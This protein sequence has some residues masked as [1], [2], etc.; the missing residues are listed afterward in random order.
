MKV[1][2]MQP[3][4]FPYIGYWQLIHA[5][6]R[7]V[8]YDDVNYIKGGWI[9]R[10]RILVNG[11]PA[12]ITV[13]LYQSSPYK[14]IC[15]TSLQPSPIWRDKLVKM[16]EITYRKAPHFAEVFP[17]VENLIR[18]E[19]DNLPDYLAQQLQ[20]MAAFMGVKTEFVVSSRC[21]ENSE[22]S[23]QARILDIC[24]QERAITYINLQ[25]GQNLYDSETFYGAGIDLRFI[26]MRPLPYKQRSKG[27]VHALSII[28]ALMEIG[29]IEIKRHLDAFDLIS[30]NRAGNSGSA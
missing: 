27:F 30:N 4:F 17:V 15:D 20:T 21:Y 13:P 22:L 14:R 10:N 25:G 18:L 2:I 7:F 28:D 1:A 23:G 6:N 24:K 19:A 12:Y 26:V 3:Y 11:K 8:I 9:N 29:P 5:V 16:V